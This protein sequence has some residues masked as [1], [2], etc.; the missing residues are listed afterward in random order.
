MAPPKRKSV[1]EKSENIIQKY[2]KQYVNVKFLKSLI[3]DPSKL[4]IV[5][6]VILIFELFLNVF[7]VE[8]VNYTEID[9]KAYM[10]E[11]EGFLN[12]TTNYAEL[13]GKRGV[14]IVKYCT[15]IRKVNFRT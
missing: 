7:I 13:K 1:K 11:C 2:Q 12:G 4:P 5:S 6:V 15:L 10:Q 8:R 14:Q 9:W 3:F